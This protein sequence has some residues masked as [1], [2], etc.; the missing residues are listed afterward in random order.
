VRVRAVLQQ[1]D[2]AH[3]SRRSEP[4][5]VAVDVHLELTLLD[6]PDAVERRAG[7]T[8]DLPWLEHD[9]TRNGE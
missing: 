6:L 2:E 8:Q 7:T 1:V 5:G 4:Q 9:D 3:R